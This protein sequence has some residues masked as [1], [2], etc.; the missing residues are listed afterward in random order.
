MMWLI[1]VPTALYG[2]GAERV[3]SKKCVALVGKHYDKIK[4]E[5]TYTAPLTGLKVK[6]NEGEGINILWMLSKNEHVIHLTLS[7]S[8]EQCIDSDAEINFLFKDET[9]KT[10]QSDLKYNCGGLAA[11][12]FAAVYKISTMTVFTTTELASM[13][14]HTLRNFIDVDLNSDQASKLMHSA[15]CLREQMEIDNLRTTEQ[16]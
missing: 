9:R 7:T 12:S 11:I 2:Q 13:R 4:G 16:Q 10:H 3:L 5:T 15:G 6:N 1:A 14:L 8:Q